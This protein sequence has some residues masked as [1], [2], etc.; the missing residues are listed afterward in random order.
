ML[1]SGK[2]YRR[3]GLTSPPAT[4]STA[5]Q[6]PKSWS[7]AAPQDGCACRD[8]REPVSNPCSACTVPVRGW[9]CLRPADDVQRHC[10]MRIAAEAADL[11]VEISCVQ[12][13]AQRR[14]RAEPVPCTRA[15]A[16]SRPYTPDGQLPSAPRPRAPPNAEPN[17]RKCSR[18]IWCPSR[19]ECAS[20][21][22]IGKPL[23]L[24]P[25]T[26]RPLPIVDVDK[27]AQIDAPEGM[28]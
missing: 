3:H 8:S 23:R 9:A 7:A 15:C 16:G 28:G 14:E 12:R 20:L 17:C 5:D 18:E 13:V 1:H 21:A 10:L 2:K 24:G 26:D 4:R 27:S 11:K 6:A 22:S 19:R 25:G